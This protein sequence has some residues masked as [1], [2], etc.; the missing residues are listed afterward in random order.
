MK[1]FFLRQILV[2]GVALPLGAM[3]DARFERWDKNQNGFLEK[4]ELPSPL[5]RNFERVDAN[6]DG[7]ISLDEHLKVSRARQNG[8]SGNSRT[9][10]YRLIA[11]IPYAGTDNPRQ[12]LDLLLPEKVESEKYPVVVFIHG[13]AWRAGS[14]AS[15]RS[16]LQ[17]LVAEGRFAGVSVG[18]RLSSEAKWPAQIHD[19]KAA[20][21]WVRANAEKYKLDASRIAV[22]GSSAGGHLVNMLGV[23]GGVKELE[24]ALGP[25]T[26]ESSRVT[27]VVNFFG[28]TKLL[29]MNDYGGTMDHDAPDSPESQLIGGPIQEHK[30]RANAASPISYVSKDD[31]PFLHV[32][33][34][35]DPLVPFNQAEIFHSAL[36]QKGVSTILYPVEGAGHGF[37][38]LA[39]DKRVAEFLEQHLLE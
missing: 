35:K 24:G 10:N 34:T 9:Q 27:C 37:R 17:K 25:H 26:N 23:S 6:K 22:W 5:R 21:R 39:V 38:E 36:K 11:D 1:F 32:H 29:A 3:A 13:G 28:P 31:A 30:E 14:K 19:C 4:G 15:G 20:I 8:G 12:A 33:G 18:Y 2:L 16:K 7:V